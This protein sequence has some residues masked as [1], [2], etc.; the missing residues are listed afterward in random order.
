M[1][2]ES[3]VF[4]KGKKRKGVQFLCSVADPLKDDNWYLNLCHLCSRVSCGGNW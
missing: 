1:K 4:M 2:E 3:F